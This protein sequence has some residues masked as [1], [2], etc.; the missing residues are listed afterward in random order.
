MANL[1]TSRAG[2]YNRRLPGAVPAPTVAGATLEA[3]AQQQLGQTVAGIGSDLT[4]LNEK[5]ISKAEATE[6]SGY[7]SA[8]LQVLSDWNRTVQEEG[9]IDP[10]GDQFADYAKKREA[11]LIGNLQYKGSREAA[12]NNWTQ[13]SARAK[14]GYAAEGL[15]REAVAF[16]SALLLQIEQ[17]PNL[18]KD[19]ASAEAAIDSVNNA[20]DTGVKKDSPAFEIEAVNQERTNLALKRIAYNF[21]WSDFAKNPGAIEEANDILEELNGGP[22]HD[23]AKFSPSEIQGMKDKAEYLQSSDAADLKAK[24]QQLA[25]QAERDIRGWTREGL[26]KVPGTNTLILDFI[27]T[28]DYLSPALQDGLARGQQAIIEGA[29]K[30]ETPDDNTRWT[31]RNQVLAAMGNSVQAAEE[32][33]NEKMA[34]GKLI[35][36]DAEKL[37]KVMYDTDLSTKAPRIISDLEETFNEVK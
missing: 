3:R 27:N 37:Y 5:R 18:V 12:R 6:Y 4:K 22:V 24:R 26:T 21:I 1:L 23:G 8:K 34:A 35:M 15:K 20:N 32:M 2:S 19:K 33:L 17:A 7:E 29:K 30:T 16:D 28:F 10:D 25:S 9:I 14:F 11:D 31:S 13:T 36:S